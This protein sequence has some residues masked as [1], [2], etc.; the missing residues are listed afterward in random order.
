MKEIISALGS[1]IVLMQN[2]YFLVIQA[3]PSQQNTFHHYPTKPLTLLEVQLQS[4]N[5]IT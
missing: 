3:V 5:H 4:G 1:C 2:A